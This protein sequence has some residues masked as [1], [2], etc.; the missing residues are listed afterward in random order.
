MFW[1]SSTKAIFHFKPLRVDFYSGDKLVISTNARGM[2][3]FEHLREKNEE[4]GRAVEAE[5]EPDMWE[6]SY[7]GH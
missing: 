5:N 1:D 6:E 4:T 7:G 2:M 3:K